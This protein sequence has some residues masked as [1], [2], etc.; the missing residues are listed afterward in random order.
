[1][2]ALAERDIDIPEWVDVYLL[3]H[4]QAAEDKTALEAVMEVEE[5]RVRLEREAEELSLEDGCDDAIAVR[6]EEVYERLEQLDADQAR[7]HAAR[8]LYGLGFS[9][10]MQVCTACG[11]P[12]G[13]P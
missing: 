3:A 12:V 11:P 8:I 9:H 10:E 7:V 2:R 4:E 6:L 1:M 13:T 5:E